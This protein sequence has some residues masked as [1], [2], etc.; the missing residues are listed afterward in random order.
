M[1]AGCCD[2]IAGELTRPALLWRLLARGAAKNESVQL[3]GS[4]PL[5]A[6]PIPDEYPANRKSG[7]KSS[8][9][10]SPC[11][12]IQSNSMGRRL[13]GFQLF[14]PCLLKQLVGK[15]VQLVGCLITEKP[16]QTKHDEPMEFATFEDLT[17]LYDVT[18]FPAV[19]RRV[20]HLLET[21]RVYLLQGLV[22]S[23]FNVVT[24][25]LEDLVALDHGPVEEVAETSI[26]EREG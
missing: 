13:V 7:M 8:Y 14:R 22:E 15:R 21:C 19:Y 20:C 11:P 5:S 9:L 18:I 3:L 12:V 2:S 16:A 24:V 23:S 4:A 10:A 17:A 6:L 25:T 1:K 26:C